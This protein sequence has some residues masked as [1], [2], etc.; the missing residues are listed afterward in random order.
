MVRMPW[1]RA[2]ALVAVVAGRAPAPPLDTIV[3]PAK[4]DYTMTTLPNG[5]QVV[6]L[7]DHSTPIVHLRR[8]GTTSGRRT[9]RPAAPGLPTCSST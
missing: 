5:L 2:L 7:E 6:F 8:S 9:R 4:F 1:V 3:R